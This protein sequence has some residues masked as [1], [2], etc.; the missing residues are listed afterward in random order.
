M[1][2]HPGAIS[3]ADA[4]KPKPDA[5]ASAIEVMFAI[6]PVPMLLVGEDGVIR[7][8][9][10]ELDNLF[11]YPEGALVGQWYV[12]ADDPGDTFLTG[13]AERFPEATPYTA[14][15]CHDVVSLI[16]KAVETKR[17]S[18]EQLQ[19][20]LFSLRDFKGAMG[21][22]SATGDNRFSLPAAV[23]VVTEKGFE[24]LDDS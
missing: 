24:K 11:K 16:A 17:T 3:L 2:G 21:E 7:L 1:M 13:Y 6:C 22:Y 23:K 10:A 14:G 19:D 15:N 5:E 8:T 12:Q 18:G 20:F 9:N 4:D